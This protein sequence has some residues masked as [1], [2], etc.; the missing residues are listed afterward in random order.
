[1]ASDMR[2]SAGVVADVGNSKNIG[3]PV[4][5]I[6]GLFWGM[7]SSVSSDRL[8]FFNG[9]YA[10]IDT[11][12]EKWVFGDDLHLWKLD[13]DLTDPVDTISDVLIVA[14]FLSSAY[15]VS[16]SRKELTYKRSE[17]LGVVKPSAAFYEGSIINVTY[18]A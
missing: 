4:C 2:V 14:T 7:V 3:R 15:E 13:V 1:M 12:L 6:N 17:C 8:N 16:V 9:K 5:G 18:Y 10:F 11:Y